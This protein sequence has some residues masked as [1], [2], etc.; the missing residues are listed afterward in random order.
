MLVPRRSLTP[1]LLDSPH[2]K[3]NDL[4]ANLRDIRWL[5][6]WV[7]GVAIA[8]RCT[9]QVTAGMSSVRVLDVATGSADIP[10][11]LNRWAHHRGLD[12]EVVGLDISDEILAE[13]RHTVGSCAIQLVKGDARRLPFDDRTFDVVLCSLALH[14]LDSIGAC[15]ALREMWRVARRAV[16][17]IDLRRSYPAYAG[18]WMVTRAFARNRMTRHDGPL[19]VLRAYTP[20]EVG[21]LATAAGLEGWAVRRR[22]PYRQVLTARRTVGHV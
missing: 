3:M 17:V 16:I 12:L 14:H 8:L 20:R 9:D 1:E 10:L 2:V 21:A 11:A 13:A 7:G 22:W 18:T 19:S 5:N 15:S 4:R 6:R